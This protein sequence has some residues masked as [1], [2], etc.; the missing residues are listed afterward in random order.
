MSASHST[1]T[2]LAVAFAG[3]LMP[4]LASFVAWEDRVRRLGSSGALEQTWAAK[5]KG[6]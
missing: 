4:P 5:C 2:L 1:T 3:W 6:V